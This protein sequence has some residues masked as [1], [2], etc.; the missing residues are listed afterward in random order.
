[1]SAIAIQAEM[2]RVANKWNWNFFKNGT[3]L[4]S[5]LMTDQEMKPENKEIIIQ[6]WKAQFQGVNNAHAVAIL[7]KGLKYQAMNI[8]KKELDFVESKRFTRDEILAIFKIPPAVVGITENANKASAQVSIET[9]FR[10]CISPLAT[11]IAQVITENLFQGVGKFEFVNVVPTDVELL[12]VDMDSG[13][14][15]INEY[16]K[17]RGYAPIQGGDVLPNKT[18]APVKPVAPEKTAFRKSIESTL[19]KNTK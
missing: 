8:S 16:R 17:A 2:D 14:I 15:T 7:D 19:R 11:Q 1:M 10:I 13:A 5:M 3:T 9:Y 4:G 18:E 6:K 12:K